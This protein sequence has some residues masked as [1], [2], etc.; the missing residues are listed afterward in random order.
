MGLFKRKSS[1]GESDILTR[2]ARL[3]DKGRFDEALPVIREIVAR[4][5][6][7][8]T[9]WFNLGTCLSEL[10]SHEEA[11]AA[12]LRAYELAPEDGG[13]LYR[14][15]LALAEADNPGELYRV[16]ERECELDPELIHNFIE[17]PHLQPFFQRPEFAALRERYENR[18]DA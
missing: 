5:P 6:Q 9:S 15:C 18:D 7:T 14:G 13:A 12:F 11:A 1:N 8:S 3:A 16:A 2:Y 10:G 4:S 17:D